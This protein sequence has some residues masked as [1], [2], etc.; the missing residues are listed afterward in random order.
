MTNEASKAL[1]ERAQELRKRADALMD[2]VRALRAYAM[3]ED[4]SADAQEHLKAALGG[5]FVATNHLSQAHVEL[6][7]LDLF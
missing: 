3:R 2:D 1:Q 7:K 5:L 4:A 6:G